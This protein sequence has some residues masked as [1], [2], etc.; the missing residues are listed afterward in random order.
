MTGGANYPRADLY[1][2]VRVGGVWQPAVNLGT[3]V[4]TP[5]SESSPSISPDGKRLFFTSERGFTAIPMPTELTLRSFEEGAHAILNGR[6]NVYSIPIGRLGLTR[7]T[8]GAK[9]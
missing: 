1:A 6:G 8:S 4:N 7:A 3:A 2:S 5:A 9:Q